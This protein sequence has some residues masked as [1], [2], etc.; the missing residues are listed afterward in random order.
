MSCGI[1]FDLDGTLLDTLQDLTDATNHTLRQFGSP[2][3]TAAQM[4]YIIGSGAFFQRTADL[5]GPD[6]LGRGHQFSGHGAPLKGLV[7]R[8]YRAILGTISLSPQFGI[9][10]WHPL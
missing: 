7:F 3:K 2:E 4:R 1:L 6:Y 5:F 9:I 10:A 8:H